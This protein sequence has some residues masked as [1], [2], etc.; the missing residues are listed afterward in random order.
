MLAWNSPATNYRNNA[1]SVADIN[2]SANSLTTVNKAKVI[3][4]TDACHSGKMAGDFYKGRQL[5]ATNLQL[6]LNNQ[7]RLASCEAGELAAE[8]PG[9]GGG[10]GVFSYY[11]L[12]GLQGLATPDNKGIIPLN[13]LDAFMNASFKTDKGL[14]LEKH[15]QNPVMEGSP[16]F[17]IAMVDTSTLAQLKNAKNGEA[18]SRIS[19]SG[20]QSLKTLGGQPI[21]NFLQQREPL[22]WILFFILKVITQLLLKKSL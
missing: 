11:L 10:R 15:K 12:L 13:S 21:D 2:E 1:I 6:V 9:W 14:A 8:G 5:T 18:K 7:V 4:I 22:N 3:I 19:L 16:L 17:P 20:L